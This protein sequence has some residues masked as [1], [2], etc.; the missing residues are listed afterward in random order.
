MQKKK[1]TQKEENEWKNITLMTCL[2]STD[3]FKK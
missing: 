1:K 3:N 2:I